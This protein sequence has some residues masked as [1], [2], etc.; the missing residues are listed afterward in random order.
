[1]ARPVRKSDPSPVTRMVATL[2]A[3]GRILIPAALREELGLK[4]GDQLS[5]Q[6]VDG[7]LR[8]ITRQAA[9]ARLQAYCRA[10]VGPD[11]RNIVDEFI[12]ERRLEAERE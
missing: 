11:R 8:A 9:I 6:A 3:D 7:E 2:G 4:P 5:L 10:L 12:A 1:M